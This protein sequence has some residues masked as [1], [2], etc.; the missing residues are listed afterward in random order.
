MNLSLAIELLRPIRRVLPWGTFLAAGLLGCA[1]AAGAAVLCDADLPQSLITP[2]RC[3]GMAGGLGAAFVLDDPAAATIEVVPVSRLAR[4]L[5]RLAITLPWFAAWWIADLTLIRLVFGPEVFAVLPLR[6]LSVEAATLTVLAVA[7]SSP[8]RRG[9]SAP[10]GG[11]PA[12][13]MLVAL[14]CLT[15]W[16]PDQFRPPPALWPVLRSGVL[17]AAVIAVLIFSAEWTRPRRPG[18]HRAA[19]IDA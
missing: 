10:I 9:S 15:L 2:L 11:G 12:S 17:A 6:D 19:G 4:T 13:P 1:F 7:L 8:R 14:G 16:L 18:Y 5:S 3:A